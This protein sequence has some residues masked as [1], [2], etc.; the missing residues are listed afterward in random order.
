MKT[1]Q[2]KNRVYDISQSDCFW[3]ILSRAE[4]SKAT[5]NSDDIKNNH[6]V[7]IFW[8]WDNMPIRIGKAVKLRN[9][10]MQY[11]NSGRK[12]PFGLE[13]MFDKIQ[14]V[15]VIYTYSKQD[16]RQLELDL[17]ETHTPIFNYRDLYG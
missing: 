9:R 4:N 3:A 14:Y 6:G 7:Y 5:L 15:S 11:F 10:I 2:G 8:G 17:I 16:S 12:L 1:I 13:D